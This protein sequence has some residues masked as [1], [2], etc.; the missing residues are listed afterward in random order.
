MLNAHMKI[1][2]EGYEGL[3]TKERKLNVNRVWKYE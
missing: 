3:K 1:K 2:A